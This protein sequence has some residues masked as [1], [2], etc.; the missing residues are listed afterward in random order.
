MQ[1]HPL[2]PAPAPASSRSRLAFGLVFAP[3]VRVRSLEDHPGQVL[4]CT[5]IGAPAPGSSQ[6]VV[7]TPHAEHGHESQPGGAK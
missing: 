7:P 4:P 6:Q 5:H 1:W 2:A 3:R